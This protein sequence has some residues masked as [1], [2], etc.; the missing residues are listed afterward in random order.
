[1]LHVSCISDCSQDLRRILLAILTL[2]L[3][4]V[5]I[6]G[7]QGPK[8]HLTDSPAKVSATNVS[9]TTVEVYLSSG[10]TKTGPT[11]R[12]SIR[13]GARRAAEL[14]ITVN[15]ALRYQPIDGFGS[16][17]SESSAWLLATN[18]TESQ[19]NDLLQK[20]FDP[21]K[22]IGLSLLRQP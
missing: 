3:I 22:G 16:S 2:V 10:E 11:Q 21:Q 12:P 17:L 19:R 18:L 15:P 13:F 9:G 5:G 8:K 4:P 20:L 6:A 7:A 1:M 14:T